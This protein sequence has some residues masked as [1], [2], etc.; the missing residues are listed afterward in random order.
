MAGSRQKEAADSK[1][2]T[3]KSESYNQKGQPEYPDGER[4]REQTIINPGEIK[5]DPQQK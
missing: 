4:A 1:V 2:L 5:K 3:A